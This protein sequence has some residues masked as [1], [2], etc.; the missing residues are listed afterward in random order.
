MTKSAKLLFLFFLMCISV[1]TF[2]QSLSVQRDSVR[3]AK[4]MDT[5]G[6]DMSV[7]DFETKKID[8]KVRRTVWPVFWIILWRITNRGFT[9]ENLVR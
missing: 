3:M 4:Y 7:P 2:A 6:L 8:V 5:I 9:T 1:V